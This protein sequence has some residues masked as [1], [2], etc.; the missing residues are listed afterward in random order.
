MKISKIFTVNIRPLTVSNTPFLY[1]DLSELETRFVQSQIELVLKPQCLH[2][3]VETIFPPASRKFLYGSVKLVQE[4]YEGF[5]IPKIQNARYTRNLNSL[6][7]LERIL[8]ALK[9][10]KVSQSDLLA[11]PDLI[12]LVK[13]TINVFENWPLGGVLQCVCY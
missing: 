9:C 12:L 5:V 7:K 2:S 11:K 3:K 13:L 6:A 4:S 1:P 10:V 8:S